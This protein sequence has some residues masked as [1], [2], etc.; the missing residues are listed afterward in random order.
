MSCRKRIIVGL[1]FSV[2]EL[3]E[4]IV[5][6][7]QFGLCYPRCHPL[8]GNGRSLWWVVRKNTSSHS[9]A[10]VQLAHGLAICKDG[11]CSWKAPWLGAK[12]FSALTFAYPERSTVTWRYC[13][14]H[15]HWEHC[16]NA[17]SMPISLHPSRCTCSTPDHRSCSI[18]SCRTRSTNTQG[19]LRVT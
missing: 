17:G 12:V 3:V 13:S 10:S 14:W 4:A 18:R 15:R 19:A 2:A 1:T 8:I 7:L 9:P 5:Y 11:G 16:H 6:I